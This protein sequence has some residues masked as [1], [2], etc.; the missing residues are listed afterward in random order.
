MNVLLTCV[1]RR[2]YLVDYFK[3]AVQPHGCVIAANSE[4]LTSGMIAA[5]KAYTVPRVDSVEYIPAVLDICRTK[6]VRMVVSLFD[7]DLPYLSK[8]REQFIEAGIEL[9]VSDPWV[10]DVA[11]DKWKTWEFLSEHGIASPNTFLSIDA[12][13]SEIHSGTL[14]YPLIIKPR[15]GMGS[16]SVFRADNDEELAF[17]Y[18]YAHRQIEKSYLNILS[19]DQLAE[20]VVI[21]EFISGKEYGL[22]IFNDLSGRHLQ[23]ITKQKLAMRSGETDMA[24]VIVD[25]RLTTLGKQLA[26]VLKHR[27]NIDVDVLE[28]YEGNLFVLELNARFGGGYPFSHLAG[29]DFPAALVAMAEGKAPEIHDLNIGCIGLKSINIIK[30]FT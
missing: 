12:V 2:S 7:I 11:N 21:Q 9:I 4:P 6:N 24:K 5:D 16:L 28:D 30:A 27:G 29:A 15:W 1:G 17:F 23:T 18:R 25:T 14:A 3:Q 26:N 20:S 8:A 13:Y 19:G 10:I 22:D